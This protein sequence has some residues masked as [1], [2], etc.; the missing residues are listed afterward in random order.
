MK[1]LLFGGC[2]FTWGQGLY[3]YSDLNRLKDP[4]EWQFNQNLVTTSHI[5]F[6][7]TIRYPRLIANHFKTFEVFK[8]ENG[9]SEDETFDFFDQV[10][11]IER[12]ITSKEH[13]IARD[14]R[15][16]YDDFEFI[17]LQTSQ[18]WRNKFY[19]NLDGI[20]Q[21]S[22]VWKSGIGENIEN[23]Q[24]WLD[25]N[26]L[27]FED[28]V[29]SFTKQQVKRIKEKFEFYESKGIKCLL[30]S[31]ETHHL[32]FIKEDKFLSD[33]FIDLEYKENFY[34]NIFDMISKNPELEISKD[35]ENLGPNP[36]KD[37]HPSKL[38]HEVFANNIIKKMKS[39]L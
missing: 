17:I 18:I 36:P 31:W 37:H 8:K 19:F 24:K 26:N 1:G 39:R 4:P 20:D 10:F 12:K 3:F 30:F 21:W 34:T 33:R 29:E 27:E 32:P 28:W 6:K 2:S 16:H 15:F 14:Q 13:L 11:D 5:K 23:F 25:V 9:G 35:Y 38:C 22:F 7:D